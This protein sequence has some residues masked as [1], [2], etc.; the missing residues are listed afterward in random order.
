MDMDR[1]ILHV[2]YMDFSELRELRA[3]DQ[4]GNEEPFIACR[5]SRISAYL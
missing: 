4:A 2:W 5:I 3:L 1:T